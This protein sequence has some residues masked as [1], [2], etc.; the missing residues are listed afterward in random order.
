M[1]VTEGLIP[2]GGYNTW[3]RIVGD[4]GPPGKVPLLCLHGGPGFT[5]GAD[6]DGR[7]V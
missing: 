6:A 4:G 3:Y 5:C 1:Q 2:F 7:V